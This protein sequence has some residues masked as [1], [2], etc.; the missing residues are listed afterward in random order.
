MGEYT[1]TDSGNYFTNSS[2]ETNLTNVLDG[3]SS[4]DFEAVSRAMI[5][6][7]PPILF[8]IGLTGNILTILILSKKKNRITSTAVFLMFLAVSDICILLTTIL[9]HWIFIVWDFDIRT[10]N[11]TA[12]KLHVFL[13]Y[14]SI[15]FSSWVLVLVTIERMICVL[16]PHKVHF[17]MNR[18]K[19]IISLVVV[20]LCLFIANGHFFLG[21]K[22]TYT[23]WH[24]ANRTMCMGVGSE[25]YQEFMDK[26]WTW[27]D[28]CLSFAIPCAL[29]LIGNVLILVQLSRISHRR[30]DM[31]VTQQGKHTLTILLHL[32]TIVFLVS[33]APYAIFMIVI[34]Y[35]LENTT[36]VIHEL[37]TI[38]SILRILLLLLALNP[39]LNFILYFLS[40]SKFRTEVRSLL[41]CQE[42]RPESVF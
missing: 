28:L 30:Q 40:G 20:A 19:G 41:S 1:T 18:K 42:Y 2:M 14:F 15:H 17:L 4:S 7:I 37:E 11:D 35:I 16:I 8:F 22:I 6:I 5:R 12:C 29:I 21:A 34:P 24:D 38:D 26:I 39:T 3:G 31:G 36:D 10:V 33:M 27:I 25:I 13:T 9:T 32:L 23:V